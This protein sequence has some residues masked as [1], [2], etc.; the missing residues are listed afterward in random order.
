MSLALEGL[1]LDAKSKGNIMRFANHSCEPNA[2][3]V[4]VWVSAAASVAVSDCA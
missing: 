2:E 1:F 3:L 4:K